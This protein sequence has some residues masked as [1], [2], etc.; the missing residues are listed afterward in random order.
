MSG[1]AVRLDQHFV[2][3]AAAAVAGTFVAVDAADAAIVYSGV[4]DIVVDN[5][6]S[7][8]LYV[9]LQTGNT[10]TSGASTPNYDFNIFNVGTSQPP[11]NGIALFGPA[12]TRWVGYNAAGYAYAN[13]LAAGANIGP[14]STF[15]T[16]VSGNTTMMFD[17][18]GPWAGAPTIDGFLGF[19][20]NDGGST[21][22]GWVRVSIPEITGT[23]AY[24]FTVHDWAYE[25]DASAAIGAGVVPEPTSLGLLAAGAAGL[26]MRRRGAIA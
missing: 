16:P 3:C 15:S 12:T 25:S 21:K 23:N 26:L 11:A 17:T 14:A 20:F 10:G 6:N 19:Q 2:A 5:T 18:Y 24:R 8:G 4:R 9:D 7:S 1:L 22:Y 13:K